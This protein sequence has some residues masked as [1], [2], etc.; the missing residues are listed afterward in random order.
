MKKRKSVIILVFCILFFAL[1]SVVANKESKNI[2][3]TNEIKYTEVGN[4]HY[5]VYLKDKKYYNKDYLDEGM[6][7]ISGIID[8]IEVTY[9]Y[10]V[11]MENNSTFDAKKRVVA[12]ISI[13]DR[14]SND[15]VIYNT[16]ETLKEE[17]IEK[18]NL[19]VSDVIK[20]DYSKYNNL[21][22]EFKTSYGISANCKLVVNYTVEYEANNTN[23]K[24]KRIMSIE[25]PLSEQ[26]INIKKSDDINNSSIFVG[27]TTDAPVNKVMQ[28]L[29]YALG[30]VSALSLLA[31]ITKIVNAKKGESKYDAF[32]RKTLREYDSYITETR[33]V[34][35]DMSK[36]HIIVD[37]FKELLD[38]RNNME[39][40]IVYVKESNDVSKFYIIGDEIYEYEAL[41]EDFEK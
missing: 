3:T 6:Q 34:K 14:D 37:S 21:T 26:M 27:Q 17:K 20:I 5:K 33:D 39:K 35:L 1:A 19:N 13:V 30:A 2:K 7:Y 25:I 9:N 15:K 16:T 32:I 23:L 8:N 12:D 24:Q 36:Q 10:N 29:S 28:I 11:N 38:V 22:N 31:L 4:V 40:A 18:S 41:R